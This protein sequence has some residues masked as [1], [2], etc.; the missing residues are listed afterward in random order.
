MVDE[1]RKIV[2]AAILQTDKLQTELREAKDFADAHNAVVMF[3]H[4]MDGVLGD[5]DIAVILSEY[6]QRRGKDPSD[7]ELLRGLMDSGEVS[8]EFLKAQQDS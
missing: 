5:G 6:M 4:R 7:I 3:I 8:K 2:N 1:T